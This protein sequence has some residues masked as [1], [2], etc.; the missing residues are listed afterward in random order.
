MRL[1]WKFV[2]M[3]ALGILAIIA[4]VYPECFRGD[5]DETVVAASL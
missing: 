1:D 5:N 4:E 2:V 3:V